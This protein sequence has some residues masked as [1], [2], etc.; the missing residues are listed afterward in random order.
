MTNDELLHKWVNN[1]ISE[2]E[3]EIFKA[4]PEY[5]SLVKLYEQTENL[6]APE[7][8]TEAMLESILSTDKKQVP[9]SSDINKE[10]ISTFPLWAKLAI[11]ASVLLLAATFLF[12][13]N[14]SLIENNG[15]TE[16][17]EILPGGSK[18]IIYENSNISYIEND[19]DKQRIVNLEGKAF[20]DVLKGK[21][22]IVKSSKGKVE[23]LGTKFL[24]DNQASSFEVLCTEGKVK[25]SSQ[26]SEAK[27]TLSKNDSFSIYD[28]GGS[29]L[30]Q[31]SVTKCNK[32]DV[33]QTLKE[34]E[35]LY[36]V[37]FVKSGIDMDQKLTSAFKNNNLE[38]SI[39]T[40]CLALN[41]D[42]KIDDNTITLSNK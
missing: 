27:A 18:V 41:L 26:L 11:A 30:R 36:Q 12:K 5:D 21:A 42:Y 29:I 6:S 22:F 14:T 31:A 33:G 40:I 39:Q 28:K 25:V 32:V 34:L 37:N 15:Q 3:L 7:I 4:R 17:A 35:T 38:N 9:V 24:V 16:L 2:K 13:N 20:F 23:V 1:S 10:K 8:D 19:W